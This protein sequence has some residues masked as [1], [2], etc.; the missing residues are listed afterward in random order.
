MYIVKKSF[1]THLYCM[2]LKVYT[3]EE[4]ARGPKTFL[5]I[6]L[7]NSCNK[8]NLPQ[9]ESGPYS[10]I[11]SPYC[12]GL[13]QLIGKL[14]MNFSAQGNILCTSC[15]IQFDSFWYRISVLVRH[16]H[17]I[18]IDGGLNNPFQLRLELN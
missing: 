2:A 4:A 8:I 18:T 14:W 10:N 5:K 12:I 11:N 17:M 1:L 7:A 9:H 3:C 15:F 16:F 6:Y 13:N